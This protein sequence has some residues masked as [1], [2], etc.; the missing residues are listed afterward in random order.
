MP[1]PSRRDPRI[2]PLLWVL[3]AGSQGRKA[4]QLPLSPRFRNS[5][6]DRLRSVKTRLATFSTISLFSLP[7]ACQQGLAGT[8]VGV[9]TAGSL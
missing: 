4:A 9:A 1:R 3:E 7:P 5:D 8:A 2:Q 6:E